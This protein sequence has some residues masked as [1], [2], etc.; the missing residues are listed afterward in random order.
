MEILDKQE[1]FASRLQFPTTYTADTM[2]V[3]KTNVQ[4]IVQVAC[5]KD[6]ERPLIY[7]YPH[8]HVRMLIN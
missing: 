6:S 5:S 3:A 8:I 2:W 4:I 1:Q 7:M